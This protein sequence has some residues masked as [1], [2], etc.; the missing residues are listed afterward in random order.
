M[1]RWMAIF[2][3]LGVFFVGVLAGGLSI[4]IFYSRVLSEPG[5]PPF[6][7]SRF[8]AEGMAR[9]LDLS[10][11]QEAEIDAILERTRKES[12]AMRSEMK[13]RVESLLE[14]TAKEIAE[15]LTPDQ[16]AR[17]E[18]MRRSQRR[19]VDQFLLRPPGPRPDWRDGR[20]RPRGERPHHRGP[21]P[22]PGPPPPPPD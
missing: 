14:R 4:H 20:H 19:R 1:S 5:G 10:E 7:A 15:I 16:R 18:E 11:L 3:V 13:P 2:A 9:R 8:L 6:M 12:E 17:F 22:P 21:E